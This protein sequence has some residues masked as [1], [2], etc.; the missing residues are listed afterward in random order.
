MYQGASER[1]RCEATKSKV[2]GKDEHYICGPFDHRVGE[3]GVM[4]ET[5]RVDVG[6]AG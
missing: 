5:Q 6:N 4:I 1:G 2:T 3:R